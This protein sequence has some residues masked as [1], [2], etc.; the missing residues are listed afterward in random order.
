[1]KQDAYTLD[2]YRSLIKGG[3]DSGFRFISFGEIQYLVPDDPVCVLRHDCEGDLVAAEAMAR[4]EA[5]LG[6]RSTY[7]ILLSSNI[8]NPFSPPNR[9]LIQTIADRGH[10]IALHFDEA[11]YASRAADEITSRVEVERKFCESVF[12]CEITVVSFHQPSGRVLNNEVSIPGLIN[13][14]N[15]DDLPGF[16]YLSDSN[17]ALDF[18]DHETFF[19]AL[20]ARSLQLLVHPEWWTEST[21]TMSE[22]WAMVLSHNFDTWKRHA[23]TVERSLTFEMEARFEVSDQ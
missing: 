7:F 20:E 21:A 4:L 9:R 12:D 15:P 19:S 2:A 11:T 18:G 6:V 22:K 23:E 3:L 8:Y 13:T 16:K 14:Y 10:T 1:M 5:D 17:M